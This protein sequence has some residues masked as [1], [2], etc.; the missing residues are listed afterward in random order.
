MGGGRKQSSGSGSNERSRGGPAPLRIGDILVRTGVLS[1]G[2]RDAVLEAQRQGPR[3]FGVLAEE[4]FGVNPGS[5]ERAWA[6]QFADLAP[7]VDPS[8]MQISGE[9]AAAVTRRQAWQFRVLPIEFSGGELVVATTQECLPRAM[10]FMGWRTS[11]PV[12]FVLAGA[13]QL[14]EALCRV[15]PMGGM[16]ASDVAL[17]P[18]GC[19]T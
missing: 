11:S 17:A 10:R 9:I 12:S 19:S 8:G 16:R 14:G 2:Q 7:K 6:S 5:V 1:E 3:P 13:Q 18:G 4:M 15:H